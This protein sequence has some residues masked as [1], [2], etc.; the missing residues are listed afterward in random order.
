MRDKLIGPDV[1]VVGSLNLDYIAGVEKL[2]EPGQTIIANSLSQRF[3]GKGANQ[4]IAAA[5]QGAHVAM[6]GCI[7]AD[8]LGTVYLK[9]L[10][11]EQVNTAGICSTRQ[12]LCGTALISVDR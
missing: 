3:G 1:V 9:R 12:A 6:I 4:A 2:P 10:R 7:G 8:S 11:D 5:R